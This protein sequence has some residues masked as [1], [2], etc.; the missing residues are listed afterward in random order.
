MWLFHASPKVSAHIEARKRLQDEDTYLDL[1]SAIQDFE[2]LMAMLIAEENK[3]ISEP[4]P[5]Q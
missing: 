4:P 5:P 1:V 3:T 2:K